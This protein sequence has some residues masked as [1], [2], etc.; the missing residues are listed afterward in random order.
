MELLEREN[1]LEEL[2]MH[3]RQANAGAGHVIFISGEAGIGKTFLVDHFLRSK[4][5]NATIYSGACDSLYT[6]R[7]LGPLYDVAGQIGSH[8]IEALKSERD[9][10]HLFDSFIGEI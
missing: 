3:Y 9:R 5:G 7:P 10:A 6:P 2:E 4:A 8:F 1:C